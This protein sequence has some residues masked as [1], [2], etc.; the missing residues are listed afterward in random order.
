MNETK[1]LKVEWMSYWDDAIEKRLSDWGRAQECSRC[2]AQIVHVYTIVNM[3]GREEVTGKEC[4]YLALGWK[5]PNG[6][7]LDKMAKELIAK[8]AGFARAMEAWTKEAT[9][10]AKGTP[11]EAEAACRTRNYSSFN[12]PLTGECPL[13]YKAGIGFYAIPE[14]CTDQGRALIG[15]GWRAYI[16]NVP[17]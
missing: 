3:E 1:L 15:A 8:Q 5:R 13:F 17:N 12:G 4:A 2:H 10:A 11:E 7:K 9:R 16:L 14:N 6:L